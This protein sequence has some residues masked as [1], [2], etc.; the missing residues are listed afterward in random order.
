MAMRLATVS[1]PRRPI[2]S[3]DHFKL[4]KLAVG[5]YIN[6]DLCEA[7]LRLAGPI[8]GFTI[9]HRLAGVGCNAP[10]VLSFRRRAVT[11]MRPDNWRPDCQPYNSQPATAG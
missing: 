2:S 11:P 3:L 4:E 9:P 10:G 5:G 6:R 8:I 7:L 1:L